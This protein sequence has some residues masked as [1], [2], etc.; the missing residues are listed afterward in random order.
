VNFIQQLLVEKIKQ[1]VE[2][3]C[4]LPLP[5]AVRLQPEAAGAEK[6]LYK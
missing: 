4:L 6:N 2:V 3:F 1:G 5:V